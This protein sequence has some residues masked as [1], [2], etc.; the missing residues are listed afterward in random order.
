MISHL[1]LGVTDLGKAGTFYDVVLATLGYVRVWTNENGLGYGLLGGDDRLAL[2]RVE[3]G[4]CS[5]AG[6]HLA[7]VANSSSA[8]H[9]FHETALASGGATDGP[10]GP[11]ANCGATHYAAFIRDLDGHKLEAVFQ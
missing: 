1:S 8:V 3:G 6:F 9:A 11:R 10:P 2:F 7:F 4:E 5:A